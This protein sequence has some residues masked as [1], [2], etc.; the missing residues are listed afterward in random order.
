VI[1][2]GATITTMYTDSI[3]VTCDADHRLSGQACNQ[4]EF[5]V[6][7]DGNGSFNYTGSFSSQTVPA[8]MTCEPVTCP[9]SLSVTNGQRV[10]HGNTDVS[11]GA[12]AAVTCNA[13]YG[14]KAGAS[15]SMYAQCSEPRNLNATCNASTCM[16][17]VQVDVSFEEFPKCRRIA[18]GALS[19][20]M[21]TDDAVHVIFKNHSTEIPALPADSLTIGESITIECP[22]GYKISTSGEPADEGAISSSTLTCS[23]DN[24]NFATKPQCSRISCGFFQLPAGFKAVR[25]GHVSENLVSPNTSKRMLFGDSL[26]LSC[27]QPSL[28][29]SS[30]NVEQC[31]K[32]FNVTCGA[33]GR[34]ETNSA[35]MGSISPSTTL[36]NST[37]NESCV[38]PQDKI[39]CASCYR[40]WGNNTESRFPDHPSEDHYLRASDLNAGTCLITTNRSAQPC[41]PILCRPLMPPN[42]SRIEF[43]GHVYRPSNLT[44]DYPEIRCSDSLTVFCA[45]GFVPENSLVANTACSVS[46]FDMTCQGDGYYSGYQKCVRKQ[47]VVDLGDRSISVAQ[48]TTYFTTCGP[49]Y[50]PKYHSSSS[51]LAPACQQNCLMTSLQEC[52]KVTC[53]FLNLP[54]SSNYSSSMEEGNWSA[55]LGDNVT[56]NCKAGYITLAGGAEVCQTSFSSKCQADATFELLQDEPCIKAYC[57]P[58]HAYDPN[59]EPDTFALSVAQPN[60]MM[61]L[62]CKANHGL[63]ISSDAK[64]TYYTTSGAKEFNRTC[65]TSTCSWLPADQKCVSVP[66]RCTPYAAFLSSQSTRSDGKLYPTLHHNEVDE[67][68]HPGVIKQV[69]CPLG[70][71]SEFTTGNASTITCTSACTYQTNVMCKP[72]ECSWN[73]SFFQRTSG[74]QSVPDDQKIRFGQTIPLQCASGYQL[75]SALP[76]TEAKMEIVKG[77]EALGQVKVFQ[78]LTFPVP[79]RT[80][81]AS[82]AMFGKYSAVTLDLPAGAWPAGMTEGPSITIF[83]IPSSRRAGTVAG[84]GVNFGPDGT[85]FSSP[86]TIACPVNANFDLGN[87]LLKV[88]RYNP[89]SGSNPPTWTP[90]GGLPFPAGY[91][92]PSGVVTFVKG[93][94]MSFSAYA[95]RAVDPPGATTPPPTTTPTPPPPPPSSTT[96][97]TSSPITFK[98]K[99]AIAPDR[100]SGPLI[101]FLGIV[102]GLLI[103]G[104]MGAA[105]YYGNMESE[106]PAAAASSGP[107]GQPYQPPREPSPVTSPGTARE[108]TRGD[109]VN[110]VQS[111]AAPSAPHFG[112]VRAVESDLVAIPAERSAASVSP[113]AVQPFLP[114]VPPRASQRE[115]EGKS[116]FDQTSVPPPVPARKALDSINPPPKYSE[117]SMAQSRGSAPIV[118][119]QMPGNALRDDDSDYDECEF[120]DIPI[121]FDARPGFDRGFA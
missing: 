79:S 36:S 40:I 9:F 74:V 115:G 92:V 8:F 56:I 44:G 100:V 53:R 46:S 73:S 93:T 88:Y 63:N 65:K 90:D 83:E 13:G 42:A 45:D 96:T 51:V 119:L 41:L 72:R 26:M 17:Q 64:T 107:Q 6:K 113:D 10:P 78:K 70:Y 32:T 25:T 87:R 52:D 105:L 116:I 80:E 33:S 102:T 12:T 85:Q 117:M 38:H 103:C 59:V 30:S 39:T 84:V 57:P 98:K 19:R 67:D 20:Y 15:T 76:V 5:S 121:S 71:E 91:T 3:T 49:G 24:C 31:A 47:C 14:Y 28:V 60:Q 86:V 108:A 23:E 69:L 118:Q 4:R 43:A 66:C 18:C 77:L 21:T 34:F 11:A 110:P 50:V 120:D 82:F 48:N 94:T 104:G 16:L 99:D 62:R 22:P 58:Y 89:A 109:L 101:I 37:S 61:T 97:T 35:F 55:T 68:S 2:A 1:N 106:K 54:N 29:L 95:V 7:C 81:P 114:P 27:I 112:E 111:S 75:A